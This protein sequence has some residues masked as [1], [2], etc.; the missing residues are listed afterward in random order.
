VFLSYD[1]YINVY[2]IDQQIASLMFVLLQLNLTVDEMGSQSA[3]RRASI[4]YLNK[5]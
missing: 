4:F 5:R 2:L 1:F 3:M